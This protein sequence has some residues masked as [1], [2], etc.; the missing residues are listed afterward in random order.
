ME[1]LI[2]PSPYAKNVCS[3]N[4]VKVK[5]LQICSKLTLKVGGNITSALLVQSFVMQRY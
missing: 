4:V 3:N 1:I 5:R 2:L